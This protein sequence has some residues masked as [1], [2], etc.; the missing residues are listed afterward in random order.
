MTDIKDINHDDVKNFLTLNKIRISDDES[1]YDKAFKLMKNPKAII[2]PISIVEWMMA[3]NVFIKKTKIKEYTINELMD[4]SEYERNMLA[5]KLAMKSNDINH[6]INILHYLHK[7]HTVVGNLTIPNNKNIYDIFP[8]ELWINILLDLNCRDIDNVS[9]KQLNNLIVENDIKKRIKTRGFPRPTGH[10]A[11]FDVSHFLY[12]IP[13]VENED[14]IDT[15]NDLVLNYIYDFTNY[16]LVKGDLICFTGLN[17]YRN[18]G[19]NIFD[20]C[21]IITLD[22]NID[23][24]GAL[25][26]EPEFT[27]INNGVPIRYWENTENDKGIDHNHL[28][29]FDH[30]PV[31]QQCINNVTEIDDDLFT[32][33]EYNDKTYKIYDHLSFFD[34]ESRIT[35]EDFIEILSD[36][37]LLLLQFTDEFDDNE[38]TLYISHMFE[39]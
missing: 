27:V 8:K 16:K 11:A 28:V 31:K 33:F 22:Y 9:N 37:T 6:I 24:Y 2:E 35:K 14:S 1:D 20:G 32:S 12:D 34:D 3:Y 21:E 23:D 26:P 29:W 36:D 10:C 4:L 17:D 39:K 5:K 7:I 19:V 30:R 18:Q 25:P 13:G 15:V 38:D